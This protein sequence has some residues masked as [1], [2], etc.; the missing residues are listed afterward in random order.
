MEFTPRRKLRIPVHC[1]VRINHMYSAEALDLSEDGMYVYSRHTFVPDSI[2]E[3]TVTIDGD[4]TSL[5]AK[6]AHVQPG[7]GFGVS[8]P[9]IP[10][11]V[12]TMFIQILEQAITEER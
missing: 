5:T 2:I 8:F 1:D 7:V 10:E 3:L 11:E 9:D 4:T 12:A 6:I